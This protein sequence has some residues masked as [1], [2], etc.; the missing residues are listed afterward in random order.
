VVLVAA[1]VLLI[2]GLSVWAAMV[3]R[4]RPEAART[5]AEAPPPPIG[6]PAGADAPGLGAVREVLARAMLAGLPVVRLFDRAGVPVFGLL[7]PGREAVAV[8]D[9]IQAA[10]HGAPFHAVV[11][12]GG[13]DVRAHEQAAATTTESPEAIL[14]RAAHLD[15]DA[16]LRTREDGPADVRSGTEEAPSSAGIVDGPLDGETPE[17]IT[18][19]R[20]PALGLPLREVAVALIPSADG[21]DTPAWLSFGNWP[22]CPEPAVHVAWLRRWSDARGLD[23]VA[24]GRDR[25]EV[26][27]ARP[28]GADESSQQI[29]RAQ[30][31]YAP[32]PDG[33]SVRGGARVA[34]RRGA[35]SWTFVWPRGPSGR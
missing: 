28:L 8:R 35:R 32:A 12:G 3:G 16:W 22:G 5:L 23:V 2:G 10:R 25:V 29:L 20:D 15:L 21:A 18:T 27:V 34:D 31:R 6:S 26:R 30:R 7:V 1:V 9:R 14:R 33:T 17:Q 19:V 13:W 24:F 4:P 11:L